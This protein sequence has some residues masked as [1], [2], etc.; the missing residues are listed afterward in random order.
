[1]DQVLIGSCTNAS[2]RDIMICASALRGKKAHPRVSFGVACGSRQVLE[3]AA[4][5]GALSTLISAGARIL[6]PACGFCIGNGQA[7]QTN[8]VSIRT[9]N[10]NFEGRSGTRSAGVYLTS[11]ET[12]VASALA[13]HLVDPTEWF[14]AEDYPVYARPSRFL[15]DDSM[16]LQPSDDPDSIEVFRGPNIG[17]LPSNDRFL[18]LLTARS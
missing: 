11:P 2:Y 9:S 8:A 10:R 4:R 17:E 14:A 15:I 18:T 13:G 12:A 16:I 1:M 7:P 3:M 6:E 5:N